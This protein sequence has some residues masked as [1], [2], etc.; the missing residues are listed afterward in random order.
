MEDANIIRK[1]LNRISKNHDNA[2]ATMFMECEHVKDEFSEFDLYY[3]MCVVKYGVVYKIC[4][5]VC[6]GKIKCIA[7]E[8]M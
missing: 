6:N 3:F 2:R 5:C 7:D 1:C 4:Y 8:I